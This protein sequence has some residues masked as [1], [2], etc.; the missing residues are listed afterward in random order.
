LESISESKHQDKIRFAS[1]PHSIH[2]IT[3][4]GYPNGFE[5]GCAIKGERLDFLRLG[6]WVYT[7]YE[8][9]LLYNFDW[10]CNPRYISPKELIAIFGCK[11]YG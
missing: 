9:V 2:Y 4:L 3:D 5:L 8:A 11:L 1:E 10:Y 7:N 6:F